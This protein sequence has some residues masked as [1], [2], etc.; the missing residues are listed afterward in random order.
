MKNTG[1]KLIAEFVE[2]ELSSYNDN[3]DLWVITDIHNGVME[4][5][6][7]CFH[8]SWDWLMPAYAKMQQIG[9]NMGIAYE[10]Y[11]NQFHV[12]VQNN[13]IETS[14]LAV[15]EFLKAFPKK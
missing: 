5:T 13:D 9:A 3:I 4:E 7:C 2:M 1:N 15:V 10:K 14:W 12:G 6:N 11:Y 8:C